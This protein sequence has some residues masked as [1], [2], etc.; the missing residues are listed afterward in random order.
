MA[1]L[2]LVAA[3]LSVAGPGLAGAG[4][5]AVAGNTSTGNQSATPGGVTDA[6]DGTNWSATTGENATVEGNTTADG[7][8]STDGNTTVGGQSIEPGPVRRP[9]TRPSGP[10]LSPDVVV[11]DDGK[12]NY[13][14]LSAAVEDAREDETILV[15]PG[16]YDGPVRVDV[17]G[18][19]IAGFGPEETELAGTGTGTAVVVAASD[20]TVRSVGVRGYRDG[21]AVE[22]GGG[23]ATENVELTNLTVEGVSGARVRIET[24]GPAARVSNVTVE[25]SELRLGGVVGWSAGDASS[26]DNGTEAESVDNSSAAGGG[27]NSSAAGTMGDATTAGAEGNASAAELGGTVTGVAVESR[28]GSVADVRVEDTAVSKLGEFLRSLLGGSASR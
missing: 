27:G 13:R 7:N 16:T 17:D 24:D 2:V 23:E 22:A 1:A 3:S 19:T 28:A 25:S 6:T 15:R 18:L 12:A 8:A 26:T 11:D 5:Q 4:N 10:R 21:I 20:V 14:T 9:D